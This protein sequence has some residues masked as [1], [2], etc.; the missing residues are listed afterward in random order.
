MNTKLTKLF[1]ASK[2]IMLLGIIMP[3]ISKLCFALIIQNYGGLERLGTYA[4]DFNISLIISALT[5]VGFSVVI[6]N[7]IPRIRSL[8]S[9][10]VLLGRVLFYSNSASLLSGVVIWVLWFFGIV[11]SF[12]AV[13]IMV[14][15]YTNYLVARHFYVAKR[16]YKIVLY[17][18]IC[19]LLMICLGLF[20]FTKFLE[21][22]LAHSIILLILCLALNL[23]NS[24]FFGKRLAITKEVASGLGFGFSN[25]ASTFLNLVSIPLAKQL[26]GASYAGFLGIV[27]PII[28]VCVIVPRSLSRH[29][30]PLLAKQ[31]R[32]SKLQHDLY[33]KFAYYNLSFLIFVVVSLLLGW[34]LFKAAFPSSELILEYSS[35]VVFLLFANLLVTQISLPDFNML[36][37]WDKYDISFY[38]NFF[39]L[40]SFVFVLLLVSV[41]YQQIMSF[42]FIYTVLIIINLAR[43]IFLKS[44]VKLLFA[45]N[46][47]IDI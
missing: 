15:G 24:R 19:V 28:Q 7:R 22:L 11:N 39:N 14:F 45:A 40:A 33:R 3:G 29:Y 10:K 43:W 5:G 8:L 6:S 30:L 17:I 37:A 26:L 32:Y 12:W 47:V 9:Q 16:N 36:A 23:Y 27:N 4:S 21:P 2:I 20:L 41:F 35:L 46:K 13:L 1:S 34:W 42:F 31:K 44:R 38:V 25:L 18:E